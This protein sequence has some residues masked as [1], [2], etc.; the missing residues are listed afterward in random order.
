MYLVAEGSAKEVARLRMEKELRTFSTFYNGLSYGVYGVCIG[1]YEDSSKER[2][3][4]NPTNPFTFSSTFDEPDRKNSIVEVS[5]T[6]FQASFNLAIIKQQESA[7]S[8]AL[9]TFVIIVMCGFGLL[10]SSSISKIALQPLERMLSVVR[11]H[12]AQIF[13]YTN[14]L[15]EDDEDEDSDEDYDN[16][17]AEGEFKI[18]EKVVMKLTGI[19]NVAIC[20][21][22][23]VKEDM[24][25]NDIMALNYMNGGQGIQ[26]ADAQ[27]QISQ[28]PDCEKEHKAIGPMHCTFI[29]S[30]PHEVIESLEGTYFDSLA[31]SQ[32]MQISVA[33]YVIAMSEG[34]SNWTCTNVQETHL[35]KFVTVCE[36]K[37]PPNPF[38]NFGH[39][40]DVLYSVSRY[41]RLTNASQFL[42]VSSQFGLMV[43]AV[44]HDLG[45]LC[46]NNQYLVETAHE[47]AVRYNDR[48][49]L[50]NMHCATL[51]QVVSDPEANIFAQLEKDVYKEIRKLIINGILHTDVVKHNDMIKELNLLYQMNSDMFDAGD[52]ADAIT[53]SASNIQAVINAFL[54]TA[55]IANPMKPFVLAKP[56]AY[57]CIDEFFSQG[58][59]EKTLG[60]P[61]QMLNDRDK[62]N[63]PNSQLGFLEFVILP[64]VEV[65]V[66]M[67]PQLEDLADN[68]G[69]NL[70]HW[71]QVWM[72]ETHPP[73]EA[74]TKVKARVHKADLR[75]KRVM[76]EMRGITF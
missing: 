5:S 43:A 62:V 60:I 32:E 49:P 69:A 20:K 25:E 21:D 51:F 61:V 67:F 54:H 1:G 27:R 40:V 2:F 65:V 8:I 64:L 76:R 22:N 23:E 3:I 75:M 42:S 11:E 4:C 46:V 38:H 35:L 73:E 29:N 9:L 6:Y 24:D 57:L 34:S 17:D 14:D 13:K 7:A 33:A 12:C 39:G 74:A 37:Y 18:L 19:V 41:M 68:L 70:G 71:S 55:D 56:L 15:Q 26:A 72:E 52:P 31:I 47:L 50:E 63:R 36:S 58:D 53:S 44:G 10:L 16:M 45:H 59:K 28:R 66:S 48:S 30:I